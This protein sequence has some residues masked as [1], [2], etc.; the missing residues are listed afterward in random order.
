[1]NHLPTDTKHFAVVIKAYRIERLY[2]DFARACRVAM[3]K[4]RDMFCL[5]FIETR[6]IQI[7]PSGD[8]P[9]WAGEFAR[10]ILVW[11]YLGS[12]RSQRKSFPLLV[13]DRQRES[14]VLDRQLLCV[15]LE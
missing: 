8:L 12:E 14:M 7:L 5:D 15:L 6:V 1:M 2:D 9:S 10:A 11:H 4:S 13:G 3:I